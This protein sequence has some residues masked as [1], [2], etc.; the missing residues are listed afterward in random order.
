MEQS[1]FWEAN[2][3]SAS[4]EI[5]HVLWNPKVHYRIHKCPPTVPM[6]SQLDSVHTATSNF[7]KIHLDIILP[8]TPVSPKWSLSLRFPHQNPALPLTY[9]FRN[10]LLTSTHEAATAYTVH[11]H[12]SFCSLPEIRDFFR[13]WN[14]LF[15]SSDVDLGY[16]VAIN[17]N[18][19]QPSHVAQGAL[20]IL[21]RSHVPKW[22]AWLHLTRVTWILVLKLVR[23]QIFQNKRRLAR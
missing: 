17:Q 2:R 20:Y 4:Q 18:A 15:S 11:T 21:H 14:R 9:I 1:P 13:A 22:S 23:I 10:S 16:S 12:V 5:P 19:Q 6:L 8:S 3:F 7:L